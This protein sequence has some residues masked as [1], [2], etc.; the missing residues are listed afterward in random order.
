MKKKI[1]YLFVSA[2]LVAGTSC[3]SVFA[4][5][6][7]KTAV[8]AHACSSSANAKEWREADE[9]RLIGKIT[10]VSDESLTV[11]TM[12]KPQMDGEHMRKQKADGTCDNVKHSRTATDSS[13]KTAIDETTSKIS[14]VKPETEEKTVKLTDSTVYYKMSSG[15]KANA[16]LSE[17]TADSVVCIQYAKDASTS[18][19][20]ATSVTI[21]DSS[22]MNHRERNSNDTTSSSEE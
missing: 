20:T 19:L 4:S 10:T 15:T 17:V 6:T 13:D 18:E 2:I 9:T 11:E 21:M 7:E 8:K 16:A 12:V 22:M 5:E 1:I 14:A 3:S